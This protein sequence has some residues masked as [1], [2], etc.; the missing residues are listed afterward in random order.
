MADE[1]EVLDSPETDVETEGRARD[2][3]GRFVSKDSLGEKLAEFGIPDDDPEPAPEETK[4]EPS[5]T[6]DEPKDEPDADVDSDDAEPEGD[7]TE[8]DTDSKPVELTENQRR[9]AQEFGYSDED[10]ASW[11]D[12]V[13]AMLDKMST[14]YG[15]QM[16]KLGRLKQEMVKPKEQDEEKPSPDALEHIVEADFEDDE[17]WTA[18]LNKWSDKI[19]S[20]SAEVM[21]LTADRDSRR[22]VEQA[23]EM[24]GFFASLV[25]EKGETDF[26]QY[27]T[28]TMKSL[29]EDSPEATARNEL[30]AHAQATKAGYAIS[31][32]PIS[33]TRALEM[34]HNHFGREQLDKVAKRKLTEKRKARHKGAVPRASGTKAIASG[35]DPD[36]ASDAAFDAWEQKTGIKIPAK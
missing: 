8:D 15:Q 36:S 3:N 35:S 33:N 24:D 32:D 12:E 10:L 22:Q 26:P 29:S 9:T 31:G 6:P 20:L 34:A 7:S 16:S 17:T 4:D 23:T 1:T 19:T 5:D 14:K 25:N 21:G 13:P 11:G 2:E 28:G 18:K 27:G 30:W